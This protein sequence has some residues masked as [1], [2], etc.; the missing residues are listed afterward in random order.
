M[1]DLSLPWWEFILRGTI[2]YLVLLVMVR[3]TGKRTVGQFTPFDLIVVMLL[4]EAVS[5]SL[6]GG[7]E[8]VQGGLIAAATLVALDVVIAFAS[9]RSK[10]I[11]AV[12]QGSPVLVGRDGVIYKDVLKRERVPFSDVE[13]ALRGS[14]CAVE[15]MRMAVLEADGNISILKK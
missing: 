8:S 13:E 3:I 10:K 2:V 11:D 4:S 5:N 14:D 7:D 1:F 6:N 9:A 12:V 15:D